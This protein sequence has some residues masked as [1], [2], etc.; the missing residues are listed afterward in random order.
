[1]FRVF[2][3]IDTKTVEIIMK[4]LGW[5]GDEVKEC[6]EIYDY[7]KIENKCKRLHQVF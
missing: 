2:H 1:M 3:S 7:E 6:P 5:K 4:E